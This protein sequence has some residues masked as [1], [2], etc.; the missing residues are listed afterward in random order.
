MK[1]RGL[2]S[3]LLGLSL[4]LV[5]L[6]VHAQEE[7]INDLLWG[8]INVETE[9]CESF[10]WKDGRHGMDISTHA[11]WKPYGPNGEGYNAESL[12]E[13]ISDLSNQGVRVLAINSAYNDGEFSLNHGFDQWGNMIVWDMHTPSMAFNN[14]WATFDEVMKCAKNRCMKVISWWNPS[15]VAP[16]SPLYTAAEHESYYRFKQKDEED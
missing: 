5:C 4:L 10:D 9:Q 8:T 13:L 16:T 15:Y 2:I 14:S 6:C 7:D 1:M 3:V 12:C 11:L